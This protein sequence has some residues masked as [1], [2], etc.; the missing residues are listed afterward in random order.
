MTFEVPACPHCA[1]P[2]ESPLVCARCGWRWHANPYPAA[3]VLVELAT[4]DGEPSVLLLRRAIDPG[5]GGW[6][7]P[8]GYLDPHESAE[9]GALREAKEE[10][11]L[12]VELLGLAGVYSSKRGNAV[13]TIYRARPMDPAQP[14]RLDS[15]SSEHAW[16]RRGE[17]ADWL[18]RM[19]FAAMA[20]ALADWAESQTGPPRLD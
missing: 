2:T 13:A 6:D 18:P 17:V 12:E 7:L 16:V 20:R 10:A 5:V 4:P 9:E 3:G 8:A 15:E 19:A 11:G 14:V 1:A